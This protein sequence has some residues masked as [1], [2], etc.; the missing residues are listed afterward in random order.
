MAIQ[1][2]KIPKYSMMKHMTGAQQ[3]I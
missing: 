1:R 2:D 3:N